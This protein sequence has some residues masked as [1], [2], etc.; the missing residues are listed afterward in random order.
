MYIYIYL[1]IQIYMYTN[2]YIHICYI[3]RDTWALAS[4]ILAPTTSNNSTSVSPTILSCPCTKNTQHVIHH[5]FHKQILFE[6]KV[7]QIWKLQILIFSCPWTNNARNVMHVDTATHCNTLQHTATHCNTL[8]HT[9]T[10][11]N[12][13]QHT[14]SCIALSNIESFKKPQ[15]KHFPEGIFPFY[16]AP[17]TYIYRGKDTWGAWSWIVIFRKRALRVVATF[18]GNDARVMSYKQHT[19]RISRLYTRTW[20][21]C[22]VCTHTHV[23]SWARTHTHTYKHTHSIFHT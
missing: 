5:A 17:V 6:N 19:C 22:S 21:V 23:P 7:K 1:H 8:Q 12:T 11:C 18:S 9:A 20:R 13:L 14:M 3:Q 2:K 16:R 10:H 15:T 4:R